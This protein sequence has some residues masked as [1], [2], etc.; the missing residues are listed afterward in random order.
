MPSGSMLR[1]KVFIGLGANLGSPKVTFDA[2]LEQLKCNDCS[3]LRKSS[4]YHTSPYGF[5][6]QPD[7]LNAVVE[8][9][10]DL[11]PSPLLNLLQ[12]IERTLGKKVVCKNGPRI[13]DMDL[14][15]HQDH[16]RE[17]G[18]LIVPHPGI[19]ERDFVLLPLV[20]IAPELRHPVSG[21]MLKDLLSALNN[22]TH[23][24]KTETW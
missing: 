13:I 11:P 23:N 19:P 10:T 5:Q 7:F 8:I 18:N 17:E 4:L 21:R 20:E 12:A 9:E 3:I 1:G 16:I 22:G 14:L 2:A 24:G 15:L 6:D